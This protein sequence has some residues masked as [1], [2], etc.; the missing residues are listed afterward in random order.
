[1]PAS[2]TGVAVVTGSASGIGLAIGLKLAE[3][4]YAVVFNDL[5]TQEAALAAAVEQAQAK[6][7]RALYVTGDMSLEADIKHL[8]QKTVDEFGELN[9][10]STGLIQGL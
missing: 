9:V 2:Q 7:V 8:V 3:D 4:G 5:P 1:M 6:N 10:V